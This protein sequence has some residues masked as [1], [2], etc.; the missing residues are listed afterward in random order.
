MPL[1]YY[2]SCA[3]ILLFGIQAF[4]AREK[5]WGIP[6][7]A[8][9]AT[10]IAWYI[11]DAIYN[12]Y[13][14]YIVGIGLKALN[15]A[16][17]Q[18]F[19]FVCAYGIITPFI[20][21]SINRKLLGN[22]SF[23]IGCY[24]HRYLDSPQVQ[25]NIDQTAKA[26]LFAWGTL[27]LIAL[28]QVG[29]QALNLFAPY[30]SGVKADPWSRNRLGAGFDA[31]ISFASYIQLIMTAG[32]GV[33]FAVAKNPRT[34]T[35]AGIVCLLAFPPYLFDRTRN[36]M[37]STMVPGLLAWVFF[38]LRGPLYLK[39][40]VLASAFLS[41]NFWLT[42]VMISRNE[43]KSVA[44]VL[45]E[46][47]KREKKEGSTHEGLNMFEELGWI[48]LF[49]ESGYYKPN[50]G[51]RYFAEIVNP[52]PRALWKN[53]PLIGIDYAIARGQGDTGDDGLVTATISTGMIGQGVVNFGGFFGPIAAATLMA[54]WTAILAR[55]D[56]LSRHELGRLLLYVSGLILTFNIGRDITLLVLY[57]FFFGLGMLWVWKTLRGG[58]LQ[59]GAFIRRATKELR[60]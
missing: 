52:I 10:T 30:L 4:L 60:K 20:H 6:A 11:M 58:S 51:S 33:I 41:V 34:R 3:A 23:V 26:L 1:P 44:T 21:S 8:V 42:T 50:M 31:L 14:V 59:E 7:C 36:T 28:Y 17:W 39:L 55:Q 19:I 24:K 43:G 46:N 2:L 56:L 29:G 27:M 32:F 25:H 35:M 15:M 37:L 47:K 22:K 40:G 5:A 45:S 57:P 38:R 16:W 53:K 9:L 13:S 48:N 12:D 49:I 54:L 18:V